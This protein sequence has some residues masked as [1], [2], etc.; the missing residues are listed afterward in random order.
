MSKKT[1]ILLLMFFF[2]SIVS[3]GQNIAPGRA[4]DNISEE[5]TT[6]LSKAILQYRLEFNPMLTEEDRI[7]KK[8]GTE[9]YYISVT[10]LL[11]ED[12]DIYASPKLV[13][14]VYKW[15]L[16]NPLPNYYL[17]KKAENRFA[18]DYSYRPLNGKYRDTLYS[19]K[20]DSYDQYFP[21]D[22]YFVVYY[23]PLKKIFKMLSGNVVQ[24]AISG[25]WYYLGAS[26]IAELRLAQYQVSSHDGLL[27]KDKDTI[28]YFFPKINTI[29][30]NGATRFIVKT[31][32]KYPYNH[33]EIIYYSNIAP[34]TGDNNKAH[35]Y[36]IKQVRNYTTGYPA[37]P[38]DIKPVS[39]LLD[40][41]EI[42][43]L[44][45]YY[46]EPIY[47]FGNFDQQ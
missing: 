33:I 42:D 40:K 18:V 30:R 44:E 11:F 28:I 39:R 34:L 41:E 38:D 25:P 10:E 31:V 23:D 7:F 5:I 22:D 17:V 19:K 46:H 27:H 12:P 32:D 1:A 29:T 24:D 37:T 13:M 9:T 43:W 2:N 3:Y 15:P 6:R 26:Y 20:Y 14:S 4:P 47:N 8:I 21:N 45:K 36:E 35:V 16:M